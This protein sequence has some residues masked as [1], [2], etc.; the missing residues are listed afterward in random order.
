MASGGM[1]PVRVSG[2]R[3][4]PPILA[5]C[6]AIGGGGLGGL[7]M[8]GKTGLKTLP[9]SSSRRRELLLES[10]DSGL[11]RGEPRLQSPTIRIQDFRALGFMARYAKSLAAISPGLYR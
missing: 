2:V 8:S 11:S 10:S 7:T 9:H 3:G 1:D 6:L 4:W 5:S